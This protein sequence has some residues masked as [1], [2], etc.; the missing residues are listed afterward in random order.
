MDRETVGNCWHCGVELG[1][2]DY[3]RETN[4]SG[5]GKP[6]RVCRNCRW[7]D[8]GKANQ[9]MEPIAEPVK[10][11]IRA[12]YCEFFEARFQ[13]G[14]GVDAGSTEALRQAAEDLFK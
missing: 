13:S 11:K 2:L 6:T 5:C 7:Y 4:C 12:N 10:D 14:D 1:K 3:G 8:P 9:C